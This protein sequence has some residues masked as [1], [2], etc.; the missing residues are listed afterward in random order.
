[1]SRDYLNAALAASKAASTSAID[2]RPAVVSDLTGPL[3]L[4]YEMLSVT[5]FGNEIFTHSCPIQP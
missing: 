1:M 4:A 3:A 2:K 5:E